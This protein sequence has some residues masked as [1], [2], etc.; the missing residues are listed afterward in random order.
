M[1]ELLRQSIYAFTQHWGSLISEATG[2]KLGGKNLGKIERELD[3]MLQNA[4]S[5]QPE[6][7]AKLKEAIQ[8]NAQAQNEQKGSRVSRV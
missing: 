1:D 7:V 3:E 2:Q 8:I 6:V 5:N 4:F